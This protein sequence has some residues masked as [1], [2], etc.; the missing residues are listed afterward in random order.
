MTKR[1]FGRIAKWEPIAP[2]ALS[3]FIAIRADLHPMLQEAD[4]WFSALKQASAQ[5][6]LSLPDALFVLGVQWHPEI[7]TRLED[8]ASRRL[9]AAFAKAARG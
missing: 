8:E 6:G 2:A 1:A 7:M 9:F 3:T 4:K 5:C